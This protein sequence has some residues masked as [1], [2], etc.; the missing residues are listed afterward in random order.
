MKHDQ[1]IGRAVVH[2]PL[3]RKS[4]ADNSL[5]AKAR[6][7]LVEDHDV[8]QILIQAMTKR[9]GYKTELAS[10]GTEAVAQISQSVAEDNPFDL[11][12]MDIQMPFMDGYEAT[13]IIR[14][15]GISAEQLPIIAVT[16]NAF[17]DDIR[18]C[19]EAGMQAHISKP[20]D[21]SDLKTVLQHWLKPRQREPQ[22]SPATELTS[23][24]SDDLF[25]RYRLRRE[26]AIDSVIRFVKQGTFSDAET[27]QIREQLHKLAG[28]AA[29]FGEQELGNHAKLIEDGLKQWE[30]AERPHEMRN[31][32]ENLLEAA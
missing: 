13:R 15:S 21:I 27:R 14:T 20:V 12:L 11:V 19:L 17:G 3:A 2:A 8:N 25:E 18:N 6:L 31:A 7:L 30:M 32:L 5:S 16:A 22:K 24:I 4:A 1:D 9:L 23:D 26:A 29:M 28:T 10:D